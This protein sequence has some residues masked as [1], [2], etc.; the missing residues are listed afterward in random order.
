LENSVI[1]KAIAVANMKGGVG[2]TSTVIAL[3]EALAAQGAAVLVIDADA[4]ANAS[5][6]ITGDRQLTELISNGLTMHAFFED[7]LIHGK[8]V[9]LF[10]YIYE[11][12]SYVSHG[13]HP[14]D[15]SLLAAS[16]ELRIIERELL[17]RLTA[18]SMDLDAIV[19]GLL[20]ILKAELMDSPKTYNYILIDCAPG[21]SA[22]TE[23]GVRLADLV[24]VPTIPDFLSTYGLSSFCNNIWTGAIATN[25]ALPRPNRL[26]HVLITR[27]RAVNEHKQTAA[28]LRNEV[29]ADAPAFKTL[30]TIIPE[31]V[32]IARALG[33]AGMWC[34]FT[35]KWGD[36]V[37]LLGMLAREIEE[38]SNGN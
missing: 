34:T 17:Y 38:K 15:I 29:H 2:K 32:G 21:L 20:H 7:R 12:A 27:M 1:A 14:L 22:F 10:D 3:A 33:R 8:N 9:K 30:E 23:A 11:H 37:P 4:Q 36:T 18:K 19:G 16:S 31:T 13:G 25:S 26:P 24:I 28:K 6:C 5:I 35:N